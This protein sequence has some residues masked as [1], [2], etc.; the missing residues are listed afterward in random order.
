MKNIFKIF[1]FI[2]LI[3]IVVSCRKTE[4]NLNVDYSSFNADNPT[5]NTPLDAWL[6]TNFLDEYN[7]EV[8]YRYNRYYHGNTANVV[9]NKLENIQPTMQI[10][11]DGFIAPYRKIGG[12]TFTKKYMPK[13]W[14]LFGSYSYANTA[15]PG[16][17]GTA[18]AGRRITLYGVNEY[19]PLPAGQ[20]YAWDRHRI[21]HHEFGH[22]LN[23]II[24]IPTDFEAI[25]KGFYKQPYDQTLLVDA[26]NNGFV[27]SYA[28]G[29]PTEDY[30]ETISWLLINGQAWYDYWTVT[31]AT[32][33][34]KSRLT[35]KELNVINYYTNLGLDFKAL[36]REVQLYMKNTL[37]R[38]EAKFQY[39]LSLKLWSSMLINLDTDLYTKNGQSAAFATVYNA[40]KTYVNTLPGYG[41]TFN[42]VRINFTSPTTMNVE[43]S[44]NQGT[45]AL[46]A[47]Y[48]FNMTTNVTTGDVVFTT[49]PVGGTTANWVGNATLL[50]PG[51]QPLLDYLT[52]NTF[53]ADWMPAT[54]NADG[55]MKHGGFAV[56]GTPT[57]Y[58]YGPL[59]L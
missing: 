36:Q 6:K 57:S 47:N 5:T 25:S 27:T 58:F 52:N 11:L 26:H 23:Q 38:N 17:A 7:I 9:P 19:Q 22:I 54:I 20:F 28:S 34:G 10:V 59:V 50:K 30:A 48:A 49:A 56:K 46:L 18:A 42:N 2:A 14:V 29:Q 16:V 1:A 32:A 21:M 41:L 4:D 40:A 45:T 3:T 37:N 44:F 31:A 33:D 39:W 13:E 15:D 8:V 51:I 35:Q 53:V 12:E 55:Y 24:P 43:I